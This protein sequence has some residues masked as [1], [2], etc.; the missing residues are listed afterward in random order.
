M[1][2]VVE[3]K[4]ESVMK[5]ILPEIKEFIEN[6][7]IK[8]GLIFSKTIPQQKDKTIINGEY[9]IMIREIQRF[10]VNKNPQKLMYFLGNVMRK[11][12]DSL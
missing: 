10:N 3:E 7:I 12:M 2:E 4:K 8:G 9:I 5:S 6:P 11:V 1:P